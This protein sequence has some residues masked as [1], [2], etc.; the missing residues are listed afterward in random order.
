LESWPEDSLNF[1]NFKFSD[2]KDTSLK[3]FLQ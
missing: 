1:W 2:K 3:G